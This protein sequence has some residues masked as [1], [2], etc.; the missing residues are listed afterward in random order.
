MAHADRAVARPQ[1]LDGGVA[2][3]SALVAG[4]LE[5]DQRHAGVA[6]GQAELAAPSQL[7]VEPVAR[8]RAEARED[9]RSGLRRESSRGRLEIQVAVEA[10]VVEADD[11]ARGA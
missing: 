10:G 3:G 8:D 2:V 4:E 1:G 9:R 11:D 6:P 5:V 7:R